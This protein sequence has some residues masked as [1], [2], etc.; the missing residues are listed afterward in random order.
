MKLD[1]RGMWMDNSGMYQNNA[2]SINNNYLHREDDTNNRRKEFELPSIY[3]KLMFKEMEFT[4]TDGMLMFGAEFDDLFIGRAQTWSEVE[5]TLVKPGQFLNQ[6]QGK[7][8]K[9]KAQENDF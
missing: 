5:K 8:H 4:L 3:G 1:P 2:N 7:D 6:P 9:I